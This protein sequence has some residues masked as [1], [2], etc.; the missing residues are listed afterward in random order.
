MKTKLRKYIPE[1]LYCWFLITLIVPNVLLSVTEPM[2]VNIRVAN[3]L[4]PLGVIG[5]LAAISDRI[6]RTVWLMFP[7]VFLAA[8]QIVVMSLYGNGVIGVDMFLN[9]ATTNSSEVEELLGSL[10]PSIG[11]VCVLYI[12]SLVTAGILM[13]RKRRL[14]ERFM[15][16]SRRVAIMAAI[17][18]V[19]AI[20]EGYADKRTVSLRHDIYPLNALYNAWLAI[21][22]EHRQGEYA[23]TSGHFRHGAVSTRDPEQKELVI[24]VVGETS[25]ASNWQLCGYNRG[26]NPKLSKRDD[27]MVWP[28]AFSESNTTHKSVPMLLSPVNATNFGTEVYNV[29]GIASAFSEAGYHTVFLSNQQPNHSFIEYF[30]NEADSTV[31]INPD[32]LCRPDDHLIEPAVEAM[33]GAS[34]KTLIVLH[35]Y[36]SHFNYRDRYA[37]EDRLFTPDEYHNVS[38]EVRPELVNAYDNSIVA[39]DRLLATLID[40]ASRCHCVASLL[41]TSDHGEDIFDRGSMRFLH[42]SPRPTLEQVHVPVVAWLSDEYREEYPNIE[43]NLRNSMPK[44]VSTSEAYFPTA[45][46]MAGIEVDRPQLGAS[47]ADASYTPADR[48]YLNDHNEPV[49][50]K[51]ILQ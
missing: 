17:F 18:G 35:T 8:F 3:V 12:P 34:P 28:N 45:L 41:Y 19:M 1:T 48:I 32:D 16:G 31:Y 2:P 9:V 4:L 5:I 37:E 39:T 25:R 49:A 47:L 24:L 30:A 50:L 33:H 36:G 27:V 20:A 26:T 23:I 42:A 51:N 38:P 14:S 22:R 10:G 15:H 40:E 43:R 11:L 21:D 6:G 7:L 29:K 46:Q 44:D 13:A